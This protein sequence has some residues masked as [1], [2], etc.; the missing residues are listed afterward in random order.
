M[1]AHRE[2]PIVQ[3][4]SVLYW[5]PL[6]VQRCHLPMWEEDKVTKVWGSSPNCPESKNVY[7]QGGPPPLKPLGAP[8]Q[9]VP[10][11]PVGPL[12]RRPDFLILTSPQCDQR[13][14]EEKE[15]LFCHGHNRKLRK[16]L[17]LNFLWETWRILTNA[18]TLLTRLGTT[19]NKNWFGADEMYLQ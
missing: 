1:E 14:H 16:L 19:N 11:R 9:F 15:R 3:Q 13:T 8:P 4:C 5:K 10:P 6:P 17:E 7:S 12:S 18:K 2:E